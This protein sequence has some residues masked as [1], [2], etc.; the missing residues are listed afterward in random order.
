MTKNMALDT[1]NLEIELIKLT[2]ARDTSL[3]AVLDK[4]MPRFLSCTCIFHANKRI[5]GSYNIQLAIRNR[6]LCASWIQKINLYVYS[7]HLSH[8]PRKKN[9]GWFAS[10]ATQCLNIYTR[11]TKQNIV[12]ICQA[13]QQKILFR[14]ERKT[15]NP[16]I[17]QRFPYHAQSPNLVTSHYFFAFAWQT[18][19]YILQS[20]VYTLLSLLLVKEICLRSLAFATVLQTGRAALLR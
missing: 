3:S 1:R 9:W 19:S 13:L 20:S 18:A 6:N 16:Q 12:H 8:R 7:L 14:K 10:E 2:L 5:Q 11:E 17:S 4:F 15:E